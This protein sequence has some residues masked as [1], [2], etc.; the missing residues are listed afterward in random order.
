MNRTSRLSPAVGRPRPGRLRWAVVAP[1]VAITLATL[2]ACGSSGGGS[3]SNA[4]DSSASTKSVSVTMADNSQPDMDYLP[5]EMALHTMSGTYNVQKTTIFSDDATA[6]QALDQNKVQFVT[7]SVPPSATAIEKLPNIVA[8]GTR[9]N[10]QWDM[11]AQNGINSC[12][13]LNGKTVGLYSASGVST[14]YVKL[15]FQQACPNV[16]YKTIIIPDSTLRRQALEA[17]QL[18]A[19]PLQAS[20]AVQILDGPDKSKFHELVNFASALPGI[21]RDLLLT[22]KQTLQDNPGV[23][24]AFLTAQLQAIRQIYATPSSIPQWLATYLPGAVPANLAGEVGTYF[25]SHKLFCANGG[26][27]DSSIADSLK[28]FGNGGFLPKNVTVAQLVNDALMKKV[29][30]QIGTSPATS[31]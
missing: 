25:T 17:G 16:S 27:G 23:I 8:V 14:A 11:V 18:A 28:A 24:Q 30:S 6:L 26:L 13:D 20:D 15:Y 5:L 31:C 12:S 10:D 3:T 19:T 22:N 9:A 29:L 21:G 2:A 7:D 1:I 4:G